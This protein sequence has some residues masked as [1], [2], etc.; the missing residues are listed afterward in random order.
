M[1][2]II[3]A[4]L[5]KDGVNEVLVGRN[6]GKSQPPRWLCILDAGIFVIVVLQ[7]V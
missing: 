4:D 2:S 3:T 1:T 7:A 6:D 5:L